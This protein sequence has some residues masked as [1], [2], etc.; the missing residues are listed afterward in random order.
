MGKLIRWS[1]EARADVRS[2]DREAA[3][4]LLKSLARFL[5]TDAGDVKQLQGFHPPRYR[6]RVGDWRITYRKRGEDGIEIIHVRNRKDAY[7]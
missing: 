2:M 4:Q 3:L 6:L 7:R 5:K 1:D